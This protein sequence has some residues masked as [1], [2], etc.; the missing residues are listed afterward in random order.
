MYRYIYL[1]RSRLIVIWISTIVQTRILSHQMNQCLDLFVFPILF[2]IWHVRREPLEFSDL[3]IESAIAF[4]NLHPRNTHNKHGILHLEENKCNMTL[5]VTVVATYMCEFNT[6]TNTNTPT[7]SH[8]ILTATPNPIQH[9]GIYSTLC[10]IVK[11][12][13]RIFSF[14]ICSLQ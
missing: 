13:N 1:F 6:R 2:Q 12:A 11:Q 14:L 10:G 7:L 4:I 5:I 3:S 8:L 9:C